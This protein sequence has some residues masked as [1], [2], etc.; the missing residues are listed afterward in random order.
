MK[1]ELLRV[2][3]TDVATRGI[4]LID[5]RIRF[6]TL[7]LPWRDNHPET[8]CIP[9]GRYQCVK[10]FSPHFNCALFEITGVPGRSD[11]ELHGGA[12]VGN[13]KGC[14]LLGHYFDLIGQSIGPGKD[15]PRVRFMEMMKDDFWLEVTSALYTGA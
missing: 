15:K 14:V 8:S 9:I 4:L 6:V 3:E 1:V 12:I 10:R 7:E 13:T 11:I 5:G 2:E